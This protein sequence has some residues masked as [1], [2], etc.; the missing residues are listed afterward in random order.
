[1]FARFTQ[2][3]LV[4]NFEVYCYNR[5]E[6]QGN[7]ED[8]LGAHNFMMSIAALGDSGS[9]TMPDSYITTFNQSSGN[10]NYEFFELVPCESKHFPGIPA[11][12]LSKMSIIGKLRCVLL[13]LN[14]AI[15]NDYCIPQEVLKLKSKSWVGDAV[16][17]QIYIV[18]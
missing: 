7:N 12:E 5:N 15:G 11:D 3:L 16:E 8:D 9:F 14:H 6:V 1:M 4:I 10:W 2:N 13:V 17:V 18:H